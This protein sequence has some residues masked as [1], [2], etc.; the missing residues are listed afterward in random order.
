MFLRILFVLVWLWHK[1][2]CPINLGDA[3][4]IKTLPSLP[5]HSLAEKFGRRTYVPIPLGSSFN[6]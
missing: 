6:E 3:P 1:K 4:K 2:T 5:S